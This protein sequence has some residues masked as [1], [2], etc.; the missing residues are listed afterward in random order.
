MSQINSPL[1]QNQSGAYA[2]GADLTFY[3][4][5]VA[6]MPV[7]LGYIPIAITFGLLA[8]AAGVPDYASFMMSLLV[9]AGASQFVGV[10]LLASGVTHWEIVFTTFILNLRHFLMTASEAQRIRRDTPKK[11]LA[12]IAFGVTDETFTVA[13]LRREPELSPSFVLG[14]NLVAF[15]AWNIGTWIGVFL[16][17][18]LPATL[19]TSMGIALYAMFIGLLVPSM[20]G[21]RAVLVISLLAAGIHSLLH[22]LPPLQNLS[23]GWTII[24]TTMLAA[25]AGVLLYPERSEH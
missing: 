11:M 14:L 17:A 24:I 5:V 9:F 18:G 21:S 1:S 2:G 4:G 22:W 20:R 19:Q 15:S 23:T 6:G 25:A 8:N 10:S 7:A 16:G 13:S 12:L 3:N